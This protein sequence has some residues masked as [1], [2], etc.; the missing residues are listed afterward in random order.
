MQHTPLPSGDERVC[1]HL[2]SQPASVQQVQWHKSH[3]T[4]RRGVEGDGRVDGKEIGRMR[5]G[6]KV[7][8]L[9]SSFLFILMG[10]TS[11]ER[12]K[13]LASLLLPIFSLSFFKSVATSYNNV[14]T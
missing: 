5:M 3:V 13:L 8:G 1:Q 11:T 14:F 2:P 4:P 9:A 7:G 12:P 10:P 6:G